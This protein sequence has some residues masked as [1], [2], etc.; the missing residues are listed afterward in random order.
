MAGRQHNDRA[1]AICTVCDLIEFNSSLS[2][3]DSYCAV[4]VVRKAHCVAE[5]SR[6]MARW[7]GYSDPAVGLRYATAKLAK[8]GGNGESSTEERIE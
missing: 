5:V 7:V 4:L 6:S 3:A 8:S 1:L 2:S